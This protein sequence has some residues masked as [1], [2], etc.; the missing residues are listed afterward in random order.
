MQ[1]S[2]CSGPADSSYLHHWAYWTASPPTHTLLFSS[3]SASRSR[4]SSIHLFCPHHHRHASL[5][6][7]MPFWP[8]KRRSRD[9]ASKSTSANS[10]HHR[11]GRASTD[12]PPT[13]MP[14]FRRS[15][16]KLTRRKSRA[17]HTQSPARLQQPQLQLHEKPAIKRAPSRDKENIP[18]KKRSIENITALPN[19]RQLQTS[20]HLR[21]ADQARSPPIPYQFR[22]ATSQS[23]VPQHET[24]VSPSRPNTLRSKRSTHESHS[25][26]RMRSTKKRRDDALREEEIRAMSS[27]MPLPKRAGDGPLRRDSKKMRGLVGP[28]SIVSLPPQESVHSAMSGVLEQR[29]WLVGSLDVFNPRPAVR[30]SGVPQNVS[31]DGVASLHANAKHA[32]SDQEKKPLA[33]QSMRSLKRQTIGDEADELSASELRMLMDRDAKRR[34]Q[35]IQEQQEKLERRLRRADRDRTD[36]ANRPNTA[37]SGIRQADSAQEHRHAEDA[38]KAEA[39]RRA[40]EPVPLPT[41]VHPALRDQP[42]ES[43]TEDSALETGPSMQATEQMG[44]VNPFAEQQDLHSTGTYL[45]YPA[46]GNIP[47]NP[48]ED[49]LPGSADADEVP[50]MPGFFTPLETPMEDPV[51][52]FAQAVHISQANSPPISPVYQTRRAS[53]GP[54]QSDSPVAPD[55]VFNARRGSEPKE[56]R[57]GGWAS[58]FRR[59]G[60]MSR[61]PSTTSPSDASFSNTSRESMRTQPLPAHLVRSIEKSRSSSGAPTRTMSRFREDLPEL[62]TSPTDSRTQSPDVTTMAG[63]VAAARRAK[64]DLMDLTEDETADSHGSGRNDTPVNLNPSRRG[65]VSVGSVDSEASWLAGSGSPQRRSLQSGL[66]R[67]IASLNHRPSYEELGG[68]KD[69]EHFQRT[70]VGSIGR[71]LSNAAPAATVDEVSPIDEEVDPITDPAEHL[72]EVSPMDEE[73]DPLTIQRGVRRK[74]TIIHRDPRIKSREGLLLDVASVEDPESPSPSKEEFDDDHDLQLHSARSIHYGAGHA[75]QVSAGSAKLLVMP[76]AKRGSISTG[77]DSPASPHPR[78]VSSASRLP[79]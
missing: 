12:P 67:S 1:P 8:F 54:V 37:N 51:V 61:K 73:V 31:P 68:D 59:G 22:H 34:E 39:E 29:G 65:I 44:L 36:A 13:T 75:R 14:L 35:K 41:A 15:S 76:A 48:F 23:S 77:M 6:E 30:L 79:F 19:S 16:R 47:A 3:L 7:T 10:H 2:S 55:K 49:P 70:S 28:D 38:L 32:V 53:A 78:H 4:P 57:T 27:T 5:R 17:S 20:P 25:P 60:T 66:S 9:A 11:I 69:A 46:R 58:I 18:P 74:P 33:K 56:R 71:R 72:D 52:E 42:L 24:I 45:D 62:P 50:A 26:Q 21:P 63:V 43:S 40:N 64:R